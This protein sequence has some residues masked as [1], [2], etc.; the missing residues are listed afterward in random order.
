MQPQFRSSAPSTCRTRHLDQ[1]VEIDHA[2]GA[3][4]A[5]RSYDDT[6]EMTTRRTSLATDIVVVHQLDGVV[7]G[8]CGRPVPL[9]VEEIAVPVDF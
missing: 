1:F 7:D 5:F 9:G 2:L 4:V 8:R 6:C 3:I